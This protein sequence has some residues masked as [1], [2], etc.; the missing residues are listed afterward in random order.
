MEETS[1][2][3]QIRKFEIRRCWSFETRIH[4]LYIETG[5]TCLKVARDQRKSP[6][7]RAF[8]RR[9]IVLIWLGMTRT[10]TYLEPW[11]G[12]TNVGRKSSTSLP[13]MSKVKEGRLQMRESLRC[14]VPHPLYLLFERLAD[15]G[16][17]Q[18]CSVRAIVK[19]KR[20]GRIPWKQACGHQ[21]RDQKTISVLI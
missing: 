2:R 15:G 5:Q 14:L 20:K 9:I 13:S 3:R 1:L 11:Q 10:E 12:L 16:I 7:V 4:R 19:Q 21:K 18:T 6:Q 17:D 8:S